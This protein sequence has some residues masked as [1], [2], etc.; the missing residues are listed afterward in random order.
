M[1][2]RR[3]GNGG[4]QVDRAGHPRPVP[5]RTRIRPPGQLQA[6]QRPARVGVAAFDGGLLPVTRGQQ[7]HPRNPRHAFKLKHIHRQPAVGGE[8]GG[9]PGPALDDAG[10]QILP[11][12]DRR[13]NPLP[14]LRGA[15]ARIGRPRRQDPGGQV[16]TPLHRPQNTPRL[17]L[18]H[19]H[20]PV[21]DPHTLRSGDR[22]AQT[23]QRHPRVRR[24]P[25]TTGILTGGQH[26]N[27][28][29]VPVP[30][31][32][33]ADHARHQISTPTDTLGKHSRRQDLPGLL[34]HPSPQQ[35]SRTRRARG[36]T[37]S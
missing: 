37:F 20:D 3:G 23:S 6:Q 4:W 32:Q 24:Q 30:G 19:P 27:I 9:L 31:Q 14:L 22:P 25:P 16:S 13:A 10:R 17:L 33:T 2:H 36:L 5:I 11:T 7:Q 8:E 28:S 29:R 35:P 15:V 26:I 18:R 1:Q 34:I 21:I 12:R